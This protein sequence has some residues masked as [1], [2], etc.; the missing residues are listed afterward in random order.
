[1]NAIFLFLRC[2][3]PPVVSIINLLAPRTCQKLLA[4]LRVPLKRSEESHRLAR[5]DLLLLLKSRQIGSLSLL[6][7]LVS[8]VRD[9]FTL[10]DEW[11]PLP[12]LLFHYFR[13]L[14]LKSDAGIIFMFPWDHEKNLHVSKD[15]R[16]I[17][18]A[19]WGKAIISITYF[20][21][22]VLPKNLF[23][24]FSRSH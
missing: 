2:L 16:Q 11:H 21:E 8:L 19:T 3:L 5:L 12:V 6:Y 23:I 13:D 17:E 15:P 14:F 1:M 10:E 24:L 20:A 4:P 7:K 18:N 22:F 9:S